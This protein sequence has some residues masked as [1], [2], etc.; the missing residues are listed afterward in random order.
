MVGSPA[1]SPMKSPQKTL[2]QEAVPEVLHTGYNDIKSSCG[3]QV[4]SR[5]YTSTMMG[6]GSSVRPK[7]I[8]GG[9]KVPVRYLVSCKL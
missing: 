5:K 3:E 9:D 1:K 2:I 7:A 4:D 8:P 6:F